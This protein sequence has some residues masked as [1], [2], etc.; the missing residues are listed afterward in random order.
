MTTRFLHSV[1]TN[2]LIQYHHQ[3]M[4]Y[5]W[6]LLSD[7][8][9]LAAIYPQH[10]YTFLAHV[11]GAVL[12]CTLTIGT[13]FESFLRGIPESGPFRVHKLVGSSVYFMMLLQIMLGICSKVLRSSRAKSIHTYK[14]KRLHKIL[15]YIIAI[16]GKFQVLYIL[17]ASSILYQFNMIWNIFTILFLIHKKTS[18]KALESSPHLDQKNTNYKLITNFSEISTMSPHLVIYGNYIYDG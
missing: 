7:I 13:S 18:K 4:P 5:T 12:T 10:K 2:T 17:D 3:I 16:V 6:T 11:I 1:A 14:F 15:G 8:T 9:I